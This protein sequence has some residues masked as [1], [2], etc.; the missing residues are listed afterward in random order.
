MSIMEASNA[1]KLAH[2][3]ALRRYQN[4]VKR[5]ADPY[6]KILDEVL[7]GK[8]V[9]GRVELGVFDL[10]I[11]R[12]VGM[13]SAGRKTAFSA[14]F[15]PLLEEDTEF[16]MKWI[17]LC[18]DHLGDTG[19]RDPIR[20][21]EYLGEFYV[22]E[23]N[24]RVS[25]LSAFEAP[26]VA[27][28]VLRVLPAWEDTEEIRVYYEFLAFF[29]KSRL[30]AVRF[31]HEG[32][33]EKLQRTLGFSPDHIW[34]AEQRQ[35]VQS[36]Y[37]RFCANL[38]SLPADTSE[39]D[40]FLQFLSVYTPDDARG[41]T[42]DALKTAITATTAEVSASVTVATEAAP[43]GKSVLSRIVDAVRLPDRLNAAL[44]HPFS[45]KESDWAA[46]HEQGR[47]K[48]EAA[49]AGRVK[50]ASYVVSPEQDADACFKAAAEDGAQVIFAT[51]PSLITACR[52]A[53][54]AYPQIK[55]LNCSVIM[56]YPGVRTYYSRIY[57]AKFLSGVIA[58]ALTRTDAI[59]YIASSP[60]FGV[61]A[62]VNAFALGARLTNPRAR[63]RLHWSCSEEG[64]ISALLQEGVDVI[65]N[66]DLP[67]PGREQELWGL[68][69]V[70][71]DGTF[72][73]LAAP[74]WNWGEFYRRLLSD[75]LDGHWEDSAF[76][77]STHAVNYW[78]G[79][80][81][82]VVDI[83]LQK[84]L[85][86]GVKTLVSMLQKELAGE[87]L[88]PFCR[89]IVSQD[90]TVQSD[91]T[92]LFTARELLEMNWLCDNVDGEI[93]AYDTMLPY[94]KELVRLEGIYRDS[95]SEGPVK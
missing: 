78:W 18:S 85:P 45:P 11:T 41:M 46:A 76:K 7:A 4:D 72:R 6:P 91:G 25:V 47:I 28:N 2:K 26:T 68:N 92:R 87:S 55:I 75:I 43:Q 57:E 10:P 13:V 19:I 32:Q 33:Y 93:P 61:I 62:G 53:A 86:E 31:T 52:R 50:T 34:T 51:T 8:S 1:Y 80:Q 5:G 89:E 22:L 37:T 59:G 84:E 74:Y 39:A 48:A 58:G 12:I 63:V 9:A 36:L 30:Y 94:A 17:A 49:L 35:S 40:A 67:M 66:R 90:G 3:K 15:G 38:G 24:K 44:I 73:P 77:D 14:D 70:N 42:D 27:A 60:I 82:K 83:V 69:L 23:G 65:S 95:L 54:V 64:P 81:S 20:C 21:Y 16:G 29:S 71:T 79:M 56:P 88:L